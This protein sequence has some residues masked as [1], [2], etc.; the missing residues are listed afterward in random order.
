MHSGQHPYI[1]VCNTARGKEHPEFKDI[2]HIFATIELNADDTISKDPRV[3]QKT[4]FKDCIDRLMLTINTTNKAE[5]PSLLLVQEDDALI[6]ENFFDTLFSVLQFHKLDPEKY[7]WLDVKL[8]YPLKW[9]GFGLDSESLVE[10]L[11]LSGLLAFIYLL[12][13]KRSIT[14]SKIILPWLF[15]V[16]LLLCISR[17]H[18]MQLRTLHPQVKA[19]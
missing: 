9:A 17:Q 8:H 18:L 14:K 7:D 10:L 12:L 4:D 3:Q 2:D 1:A 13:V 5:I 6:A 15:S 11:S 19:N 16:V